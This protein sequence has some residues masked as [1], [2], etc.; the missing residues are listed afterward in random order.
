M[1]LLPEVQRQQV[2]SGKLPE[3]AVNFGEEVEMAAKSDL[4]RVQEPIL[5]SLLI[6][7][8]TDSSLVLR[9]DHTAPFVRS[10]VFETPTRLRGSVNNHRSEHVKYGSPSILQE[11]GLKPIG[12]ISKDFKLD[13]TFTPGTHR[14]SPLNA[15]PLRE[16][17][18]A[19]YSN[20][21][22]ASPET[23]QNGFIN[24]FLNTSPTYSHR[25]TSNRVSTP[26]SNYGLFKDS[27]D[28]LDTNLSGKR[29]Q[30]DR[31]YGHWNV[32]SLDES[33][34]ISFR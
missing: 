5:T 11:R 6:P 9:T 17:S 20:L 30:S 27:V 10:L 15:S 19:N 14:V 4:A 1:E 34:D 2:K 7:S 26:S 29:I 12:S 13:D 31:D 28:G 22:D 25:V 3:T 23:E 16:I 24:Q 21:Q 32:V 18:K 8:S 33:M